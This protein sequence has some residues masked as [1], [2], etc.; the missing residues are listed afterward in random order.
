MF[1]GLFIHF[2]IKIIIKCSIKYWTNCKESKENPCLSSP[3]ELFKHN[4]ACS[5][6]LSESL[7]SADWKISNSFNRK[8]K[9][10]LVLPKLKFHD[11]CSIP[12]SD[13]DMHISSNNV[14]IEG[15]S[16]TGKRKKRCPLCS[17]KN[18]Q[19]TECCV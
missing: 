6:W 8:D 9:D 10:L 5:S 17:G 14:R 15:I 18:Y 13:I 1:P 2:T 7:I 3:F 11:G 4:R 16:S 19:I 12:V